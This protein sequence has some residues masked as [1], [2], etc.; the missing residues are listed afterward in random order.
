ME[1]MRNNK[2]FTLIEILIVVIILGILAAIVIPQF[3]SPAQARGASLMDDRYSLSQIDNDASQHDEVSATTQ[4]APTIVAGKF[5]GR[6]AGLEETATTN[7]PSD[8]IE[9]M[10]LRSDDSR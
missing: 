8:L 3:R 1:K 9:S 7:N 6:N 4:P 2:G 5:K 10:P